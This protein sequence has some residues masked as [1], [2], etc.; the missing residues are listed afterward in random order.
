MKRIASGSPEA[1]DQQK[2]DFHLT[3]VELLTL[4][5]WGKNAYTEIQCHNFLPLTSVIET[6]V[7]EDTLPALRAAMLDFFLHVYILSSFRKH[8]QD[9]NDPHYLN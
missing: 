7:D 6:I 8:K 4:C 1:G 2:F 5:S 3:L 9:D